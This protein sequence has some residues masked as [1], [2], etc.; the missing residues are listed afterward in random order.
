MLPRSEYVSLIPTPMYPTNLNNFKYISV[1]FSSACH[2][3]LAHDHSFICFTQH[4]DSLQNRVINSS[5]ADQYQP[6]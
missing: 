6:V 1:V 5:N 4:P 3:G 2:R